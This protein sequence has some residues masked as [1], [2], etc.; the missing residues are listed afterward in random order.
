ME[1]M[2]QETSTAKDLTPRDAIPRAENRRRSTDKKENIPSKQRRKASNYT[3]SI[4]EEQQ[5]ERAEM[6]RTLNLNHM[7]LKDREPVKGVFRYYEVPGGNLSFVLKIYKGDPV[8]KYSLNDGGFYTLPRGVAKHLN[9][10][11]WYPVH[12][13]RQEEGGLP[14]QHIGKKVRRMSFQS[15]EF[16]DIE[17]LAPNASPE[18]EMIGSF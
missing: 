3:P 16:M 4:A 6:K 14:S 7:R 2:N 8:E 5:D 10:N 17:D 9:K 15:L 11:G 12:Y 18:I 13:H 1:N